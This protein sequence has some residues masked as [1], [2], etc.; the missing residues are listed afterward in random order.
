MATLSNKPKLLA[1]FKFAMLTINI[2][3]DLNGALKG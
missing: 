1:D 2:M 3:P